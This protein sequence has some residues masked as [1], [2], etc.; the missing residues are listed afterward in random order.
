MT[1][2]T[3]ATPTPGSQETPISA[4]NFNI[5]SYMDTQAHNRPYQRAVV[6]PEGQDAQGRIAWTQLTYTQLHRL[7]DEYAWALVKKGVKAGDRVSLLVRPSIDFIPL[8]FALFKIGAL[9]VLIDPGMGRKPF[10]ACIRKMAPRVLIA[11]PIV[12]TLKPFFRRSFASVEVA[13]STHPS[14]LAALRS[15]APKTP[16]TTI[17][18]QPED[19]AAILFTSGSTGPAKGVVYTHRIFDAQT[20]FIRDMYQIQPGEIDLACFP[21]FGLFSMALGMTVVI[22]KMDPTRPAHA[23]PAHLIQA[24]NEHGCTST[25][26]SPAIWKNVAKY[27]LKHQLTLPSLKRILTAGAPISPQIHEAFQQILSNN[28]QVHT[29]Y[30]ATESLPVATISSKVI[31]NETSVATRNGAGTCVGYPAP[32]M[33]IRIIETNDN[34]IKNWR[35]VKLLSTG[36]IGEICVRG[37]VVT[38]R[39]EAEVQ[40]TESSKIFETLPDGTQ[41][42][43]HRMGDLGYIDSHGRLWFCGRKKHRVETINGP[44]YPVPCEAIFDEHPKVFK[45]ALVGVEQE[46]ILIVQL[47]E[48]ISASKTLTQELLR[49]GEAHTH[50]KVINKIFYH[51][52]LPV[53][54][55][56]NAKI[57]REQLAIW[58]KNQPKIT[59]PS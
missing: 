26:G 58:A 18:T 56:H 31:I 32:E 15:T 25:F 38:P 41:H 13:V 33:T 39:Y 36:D 47:K 6:F 45:T 55:R 57:H 1:S 48:N 59:S 8:V 16:F 20:R 14:A 43:V 44:L 54:V 50:T 9:P 51:P 40:A 21:L 34:P 2:E 7:T 10:L 53:D 12:H 24:I 3:T 52:K 22:P 49:L 17:S 5:A 29:P 19:V 30:G 42:I 11:P 23:D 35:D 4:R 27:A 28:A 46:P 37:P